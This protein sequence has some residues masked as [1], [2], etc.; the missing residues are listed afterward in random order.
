MNVLFITPWYP[1]KFDKMAGL[2]VQKHAEAV[3]FY[4]NTKV[5]SVQA[6]ELVNKIE[7][8]RNTNLGFDEIIVYFPG[9][10]NTIFHK[11]FKH[12]N[13]CLAY[14]HG[15]KVLRDCKFK[16]DIIHSN[17]LTRNGLIAYFIK[18][19]YHIPYVVTEHWS[20]YLPEQNSYN[21]IF[22]KRIT[23]IVTRNASAILPVSSKLMDAMISHG[24]NNN[25]Y[26]VINNI[27]DDFFFE[28]SILETKYKKRVLSVSCFDERAKNIKGIVRV[29]NEVLSTRNDVE[30]VFIGTGKDFENVVKYSTELTK[31]NTNISFIG[32]KTPME[33][34]KWMRKSDI[35]VLFSNFETAGIVI[36]ESLVSGTPVISTDV[37]IAS[38]F[39]ND[40]NGKIIQVGNE[41]EFFTEL[42]QMLDKIQFYDRNSISTNSLNL[43]DRR[44]VGEK[45][46]EIYRNILN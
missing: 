27:V 21:G 9:K 1:N 41:S 12:I 17:I 34:A 32:E 30:F 35:F 23:K 2:F 40:S 16:I 8:E 44:F 37:G 6:S 7:I 3:S 4:C 24:L 46:M 25:N 15:F 14:I 36:T 22:R 28:K 26:I 11:I 45:I 43:F 42:N 29:A 18:Q 5:L 33:V 31:A 39:I 13:F 38:E 20:R 10:S 19:I